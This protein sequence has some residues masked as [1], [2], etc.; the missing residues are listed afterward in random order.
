MQD[1]IKAF[2]DKLYNEYYA[3]FFR[4]TRMKLKNHHAAED[5]VQELFFAAYQKID[6]L[7]VHP[8]PGAWLGDALKKL[9]MKYYRGMGRRLNNEAKL[10]NEYSNDDTISFSVAEDDEFADIL[11]REEYAMLKRNILDGFS[12][13]RN[14]RGVGYYI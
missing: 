5:I 2:Y 14:Q 7:V 3:Y 11:T 9:V 4:L 10:Q 13:E 1:E 6:V 12:V 8:E